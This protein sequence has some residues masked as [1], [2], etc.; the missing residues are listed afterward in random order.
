MENYTLSDEEIERLLTLASG[1][2]AGNPEATKTLDAMNP[3]TV[4]ETLCKFIK[5]ERSDCAFWKSQAEQEGDVK[6][7]LVGAILD[8]ATSAGVAEGVEVRYAPRIMRDEILN[9]RRERDAW[10]A[11]AEQW[12]R[13]GIRILH[14]L[15]RR[16]APEPAA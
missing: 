15:E 3:T 7:R 10:K 6:A 16:P 5:K 14:L 8:A 13:E 2:A 11:R 9:L 12:E 4:I 1:D